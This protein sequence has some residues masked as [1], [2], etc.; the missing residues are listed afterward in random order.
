MVTRGVTQVVTQGGV[1]VEGGGRGAE[2]GRRRSADR[3][4]ADI[5]CPSWRTAQGAPLQ[6]IQ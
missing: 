2:E 5:A 3:K 1:L 6:R 4:L